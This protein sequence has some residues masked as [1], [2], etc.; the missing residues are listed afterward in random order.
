M[1]M[2]AIDISLSESSWSSTL[3][4]SAERISSGHSI[5]CMTMTPSRTR[6]TAIVI[7]LRIDTVTTA[8]RP[9][10]SSASRSRT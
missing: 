8:M 5:V 7:R 9:C 1:S 3:A 6:S 4:K 10:A 2:R